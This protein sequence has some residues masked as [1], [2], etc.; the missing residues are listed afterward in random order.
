MG[1][2]GS[3]SRSSATPMAQC[4]GHT[5]YSV[6]HPTVEVSKYNWNDESE[7]TAGGYL[8]PEANCR[9]NQ[10]GFDPYSSYS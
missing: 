4:C 3:L 8:D 1:S 2:L 10:F 9:T 6:V 7:M 5:R